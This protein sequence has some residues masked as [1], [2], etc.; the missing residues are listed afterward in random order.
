M[1]PTRRRGVLAWPEGALPTNTHGGSL[2]E[3]YIHGLDHVVEGVRQTR[4]DST[5]QVQANLHRRPGA[6]QRPG[7]GPVMTPMSAMTTTVTATTAGPVMTATT[8][9]PVMTATAGQP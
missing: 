6:H 4:G 9:G 8:A 1:G 2:S 3:A 7:P 5:C